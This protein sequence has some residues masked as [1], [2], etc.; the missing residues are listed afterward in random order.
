MYL[1]QLQLC[2]SFGR[3]VLFVRL[4]Q[5]L[6]R[7]QQEDNHG[8]QFVHR[9]QHRMVLHQALI[10]LLHQLVSCLC[11]HRFS[12]VQQHYFLLQLYRNQRTRSLLSLLQGHRLELA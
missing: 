1:L 7:H 3:L 4:L 10:V 9:S 11:I 12:Q 6:S 8:L 5:E 2:A